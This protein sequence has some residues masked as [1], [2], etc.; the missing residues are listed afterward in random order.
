MVLLLL[1]HV[2]ASFLCVPTALDVD[3]CRFAAEAV[4]QYSPRAAL[5]CAVPLL[6]VIA[7]GCPINHYSGTKGGGCTPLVLAASKGQTKV[8]KALLA[9][10]ADP[11]LPDKA[12]GQTPLH[13]AA[14]NGNS[15]VL[16]ELLSEW[17]FCYNN[18]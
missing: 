4:E 18:I 10:G 15:N 6:Q 5:W 11:D 2:T 12:S 7:A 13:Y 16:E 3:G 9:A 8:A 1:L 17:L 14:S